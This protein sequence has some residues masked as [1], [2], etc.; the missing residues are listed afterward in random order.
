[1]DFIVDEETQR[2]PALANRELRGIS[3]GTLEFIANKL[4][5][6]R[7]TPP[8]VR[9]PLLVARQLLGLPSGARLKG[10][11]G[12]KPKRLKLAGDVMRGVAGSG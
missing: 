3:L 11:P 2:H 1:L 9:K 4:F 5:F 6:P 8:D 7:A 12:C 10:E